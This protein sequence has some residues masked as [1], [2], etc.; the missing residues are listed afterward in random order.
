[1]AVWPVAEPPPKSGHT[2][3]R[4]GDVSARDPVGASRIVLPVLTSRAP[5]PGTIRYERLSPAS[6]EVLGQIGLRLSAGWTSEE[7]ASEFRKRPPPFRHTP[8]PKNSA[9]GFTASWINARM[10]TL[11]DEMVESVDPE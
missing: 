9:T 11:R 10:R 1:M 2:V 3:G 8:L 6:R 7:I 4:D 5:L